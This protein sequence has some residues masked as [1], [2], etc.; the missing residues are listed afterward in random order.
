[1]RLLSQADDVD[2]I[3]HSRLLH[4]ACGR[5]A[6]NELPERVRRPVC[7]FRPRPRPRRREREF[8]WIFSSGA[9]ARITANDAGTLSPSLA[10]ERETA[11]R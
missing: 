6:R 5:R 8:S 10:W 4:G 2:E 1:V 11:M 7:S 3:V 9:G